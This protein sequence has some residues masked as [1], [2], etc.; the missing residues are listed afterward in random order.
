MKNMKEVLKYLLK[1]I[2]YPEYEI[3]DETN[4]KKLYVRY[5][6]FERAYLIYWGIFL[7]LCL[8]I[9]IFPQM[10]A[11]IIVYLIVTNVRVL[12]KEYTMIKYSN[13]I[14]IYEKNKII[15]VIEDFYEDNKRFI[16]EYNNQTLFSQYNFYYFF[17]NMLPKNYKKEKL[18]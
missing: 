3:S 2:R 9:F 11:L 8:F 12:K 16:I 17:N 10:I 4:K 14:K 6:L 18:D 1:K 5:S 15:Y 7:M 13:K